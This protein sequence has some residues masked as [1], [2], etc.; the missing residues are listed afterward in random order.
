MYSDPGAILHHICRDSP[1][2]DNPFKIF[3]RWP[4]FPSILINKDQLA[5]F[6]ILQ[7]ALSLANVIVG[8]TTSNTKNISFQK[9]STMFFKVSW[10]WMFNIVWHFWFEWDLFH[11][12]QTFHSLN[13]LSLNNLVTAIIVLVQCKFCLKTFVSN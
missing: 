1:R 3:V 12:I 5:N 7:Y 9:L 8:C 6:F 10:M 13:K 4:L 11:S 2:W